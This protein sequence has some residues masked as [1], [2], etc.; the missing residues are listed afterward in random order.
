MNTS[1]GQNIGLQGVK[2][3]YGFFFLLF[4]FGIPGSRSI[5]SDKELTLETSAFE[6]LYG[7]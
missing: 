6:S 3:N 7:G 4:S 5:R 1:A 2:S